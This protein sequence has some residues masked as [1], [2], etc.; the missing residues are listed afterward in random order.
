MRF[1]DNKDKAAV[2]ATIDLRQAAKELEGLKA[3][4]KSHSSP[5]VFAHNDL[6]SGNV[7]WH[8]GNKTIQ[9][10]DYEYGCYNYRG[11]NIA[12]HFW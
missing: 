7:M 6:L 12:D 1:D 8:A 4:L 2:L 10:V 3:K 9:F 11:F 5:V